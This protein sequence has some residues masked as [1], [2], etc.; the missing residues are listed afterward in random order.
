MSPR[1]HHLVKAENADS[2]WPESQIEHRKS[3]QNPG[4]WIRVC[5]AWFQSATLRLRAPRLIL[6]PRASA[7]MH[8]KFGHS[9][10]IWC[11]KSM[12]WCQYDIL[13]WQLYLAGLGTI[14]SSL[15][16]AS[17]QELWCPLCLIKAFQTYTRQLVETKNVDLW[18]PEGQIKPR[19]SFQNP[20]TWIRVW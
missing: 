17:H 9:H 7:P 4:T 11:V 18:W 3:F 16:G 2:W 12:R 13:K 19:Q 20:G 1:G 6:D 5:W 10:L 15:N 8:M 14:F